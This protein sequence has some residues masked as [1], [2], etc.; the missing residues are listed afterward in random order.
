MICNKNKFKNSFSFFLQMS[1]VVTMWLLCLSWF[2]LVRLHHW[3]TASDLD[4]I[5]IT[6]YIPV[7]RGSFVLSTMLVRVRI[8]TQV[9]L[10]QKPIFAL[11]PLTSGTW[12]CH[13][14]VEHTHTLTHTTLGRQSLP[15]P[16]AIMRSR[17]NTG[18]WGGSSA[19]SSSFSPYRV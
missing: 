10:V 13:S 15:L 2:C 9:G 17:S 16:D 1:S 14:L 8:Q 19:P 6:K 12:E 7:G 3:R 11:Q 4:C 18:L 5:L